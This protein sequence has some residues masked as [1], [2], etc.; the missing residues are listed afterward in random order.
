[1]E[2]EQCKEN[3]K[4]KREGRT[5]SNIGTPKKDNAAIAEIQERQAQFEKE[6]DEY[7]GEDELEV[8]DRYVR[9]MDNAY[10]EGD[11]QSQ[12]S[13]I[14]FRLARKFMKDDKL[15]Q[16]RNDPRLLNT[17][18]DFANHAPDA[19]QVYGFCYSKRIALKLPRFWDNYAHAFIYKGM[20]TKAMKTV[21]NACKIFPDYRPF[22]G[23][24]LE[25]IKLIN[26]AETA[27]PVVQN[28][29][30]VGSTLG[31]DVRQDP[32]QKPARPVLGNQNEGLKFSV[33]SDKDVYSTPVPSN[34]CNPLDRKKIDKE[35]ASRKP[36]RWKDC[37]VYTDSVPTEQEGTKFSVFEE[38]TAP[39]KDIMTPRHNTTAL[40][41]KKVPTQGKSAGSFEQQ[42][43][44]NTQRNECVA[45]SKS[46]VYPR[47]GAEWSFEELWAKHR[48]EKSQQDSVTDL[49]TVDESLETESMIEHKG[50]RKRSSSADSSGTEDK[51]RCTGNIAES[52]VSIKLPL[53]SCITPRVSTL[54]STNFYADFAP[55]NTIS[56]STRKVQEEDR[57]SEDSDD[58]FDV[59]TDEPELSVMRPDKSLLADNRSKL[60]LSQSFKSNKLTVLSDAPQTA[61]SQT[62]V[63][64]IANEDFFDVL[65]DDE[66]PQQKEQ[67]T[68]DNLE[69]TMNAKNFSIFEDPTQMRHAVAADRK[70]VV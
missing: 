52:S 27:A 68:L 63:N 21:E 6:I 39:T 4:P 20:Y 47:G 40:T 32:R 3:V 48:F 69:S 14:Q 54:S 37:A 49:S 41:A 44:S 17:Y 2:W 11:A 64:A 36:Q 70:S 66:G 53:K 35:N 34:S 46:K 22:K 58:N 5:V 38:G 50:S 1:M 18:I 30:S 31:G 60:K 8:W 55:E 28:L 26:Q 16:Y 15:E 25:I 12:V 7:D 61:M 65:S 57:H 33:M 13:T 9:F 29:R 67:F 59:F 23:L 56:S 45:Y 19:T 43:N 62:S 24:K 51:K 10:P 42:V